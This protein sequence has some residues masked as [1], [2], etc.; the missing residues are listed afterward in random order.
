MG[1]AIGSIAGSLIG[2]RSARKAAASQA[3]ASQYAAD[4][5]E[6]AAQLAAEEAR[7]RPVG[8]STRFGQSQFQYGPEGRL[9]GASYTT[10]PE[11][12]ALQDRRFQF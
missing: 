5:Q 12:Q 7:F 3:A 8:I 2:A 10:S 11:V 6:R 4:A 9:S 1:S